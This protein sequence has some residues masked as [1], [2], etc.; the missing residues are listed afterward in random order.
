MQRAFQLWAATAAG[1]LIFGLLWVSHIH[2]QEPGHSQP[3]MDQD[4]A[5]SRRSVTLT[6]GTFT[7][8]LNLSLYQ[9]HFPHLQSYQCREMIPEADLCRPGDAPLL[10]LAIKSHPAS[11][12][13]RATLRRTW[14]QPR[15]VGGYRVQPLFLVALTPDSRHL[16]LVQLESSTFRDI[17]LWD[18]TE[19][20]YN[21]SLKEICF[22]HW[23]H[24][25]CQQ[26]AYIL[27]GNLFC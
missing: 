1:S 23:A 6:D 7:F 11:T 20:H 24:R 15:Q 22:L 27:K 10:L 12:S 17:L 3:H 18:F 2:R 4:A 21:L 26:A 19:S 8:H 16:R 5:S 9:A 13:R 25:H 14:A